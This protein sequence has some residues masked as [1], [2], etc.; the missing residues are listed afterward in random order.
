MI[1]KSK[2][3]LKFNIT[4]LCLL[5]SA[6][7]LITVINPTFETRCSTIM[8]DDGAVVFLDFGCFCLYVSGPTYRMWIYCLN[9]NLLKHFEPHPLRASRLD[10]ITQAT[11]CGL[12]ISYIAILLS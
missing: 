6:V 12:Q 2:T 4:H 8:T 11:G 3:S 10:K 1:F 7:L 9:I 5:V